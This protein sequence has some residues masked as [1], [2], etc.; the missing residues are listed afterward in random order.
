MF[1]EE[2]AVVREE[3]GEGP[4]GGVVDDLTQGVGRGDRGHVVVA[5]QRRREHPQ[6]AQSRFTAGLERDVVGQSHGLDDA[7]GPRE[8]V[9]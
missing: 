3:T 9:E 5:L 8:L 6:C 4:I 7:G 1:A 2:A